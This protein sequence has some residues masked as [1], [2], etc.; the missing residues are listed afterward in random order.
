MLNF[1]PMNRPTI[2]FLGKTTDDF[3]NLPTFMLDC[4]ESEGKSLGSMTTEERRDAVA[5]LD[6]VGFFA[7]RKSIDVLCER[8]FTSRVCLYGDIQKA[9]NQK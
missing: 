4:L 2:S 6:S 9:R 7:L 3:S 5:Y 1:D 8:S